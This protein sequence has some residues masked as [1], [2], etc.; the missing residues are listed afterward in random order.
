MKL[1]V[2]AYVRNRN[3]KLKNATIQY[4]AQGSQLIASIVGGT[5]RDFDSSTA[6]QRTTALHVSGQQH[7][8][9]VDNSITRQL[10]AA[11]HVS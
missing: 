8:M 7:Y 3:T 11:L 10:T 2:A 9:S 5:E 1:T 4:V 6:R